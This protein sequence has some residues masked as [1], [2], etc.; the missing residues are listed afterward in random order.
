MIFFYQ[1]TQSHA[2]T[3]ALL[4]SMAV[5]KLT[6]LSRVIRNNG[7]LH[8]QWELALGQLFKFFPPLYSCHHSWVWFFLYCH[9]MLSSDLTVRPCAPNIFYLQTR[10]LMKS[11]A[12]IATTTP[13]LS[14]RDSKNASVVSSRVRPLTMAPIKRTWDGHF[15][16]TMSRETPL[17]STHDDHQGWFVEWQSISGIPWPGVYLV[18]R[19]LV[20]TAPSARAVTLAGT[21]LM[22]WR[23]T[24]SML[25]LQVPTTTATSWTRPQTSAHV[26]LATPRSRPNSISPTVSCPPPFLAFANKLFFFFFLFFFRFEPSPFSMRTQDSHSNP[27]SHNRIPNFHKQPP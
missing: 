6:L 26:H 13:L 27:L 8:L 1:I 9:F 3:V 23:R 17:L 19:A 20:T 11:H 5:Q 24:F 7:S 14:V 21:Y 12:M 4:M 22:R 16:S 25:E 18:S 2:G 15:V 10:P